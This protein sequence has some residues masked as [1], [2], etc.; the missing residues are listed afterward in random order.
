MSSLKRNLFLSVFGAA[1]SAGVA[2]AA[3]LPTPPV[4]EYEPETLVEIG[5]SWYLRGDIGY[6]A[7]SNP[8]AS[9]QDPTNGHRAFIKEE[10]DNGWLIGGG[11]GYYFNEH[12]RADVTVDYR[13]E[14][15]FK[16][17]V[18]GCGGCSGGYSNESAKFSAWTLMLNGYYDF[19]TWNSVTPYVGAG[20][21]L[22]HLTLGGYATSNGVPF[23][24]GD[25]TNFAWNLMA[26]AVVDIEEGWK[27]D[28]NYRFLSMG[29]AK[30]GTTFTNG[31]N[32]QNPV[33]IEDI[34]A[35]E[36][37]VGLRYDL[38]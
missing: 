23:S 11:F 6:A 36:F 32:A 13:H 4:I 14:A 3:D 2:M 21:G 27:F 1:M 26:G 25:N 35:H 38:D 17:M 10:I 8:D 31:T 29:E 5:S 24:D 7:Y 33:K 37:R 16:G 34:Y 22:T 15:K 18:G 12:L 30:T 20:I 19:G 28:A 9:W